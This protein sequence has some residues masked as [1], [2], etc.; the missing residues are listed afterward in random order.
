MNTGTLLYEYAHIK[1][2]SLPFGW[3]IHRIC[4]A[5]TFIPTANYHHRILYHFSIASIDIPRM[6]Y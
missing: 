1:K 4:E 2:A 3:L 6:N 5:S